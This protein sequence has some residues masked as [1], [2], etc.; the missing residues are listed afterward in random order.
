MNSKPQRGWAVSSDLLDFAIE[1]HGGMIRWRQWNEVAADVSVGGY[2]WQLKS[3]PGVLA[4]TSFTASLQE[5]RADI[6]LVD[7]GKRITFVP[8]NVTILAED[9]HLIEGRH[10]P[11]E[12][13][14]GQALETPWDDVHVGYFD[15]YA[16]WQYLT[17]PFLYSYP[18]FETQEE[19]PWHEDGETWRVL[20]VTFPDFMAAHTRVQRAY[21]GPDGLLRR[22]QYTVDV[23]GGAPGVNYAEKYEQ[24]N[25][26]M[27]PMQRRVYAYDV[28][29]QKIAEPVLVTID[30]R[31][32]RFM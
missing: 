11:R 24:V 23:L 4:R 10:N 30:I 3:R 21:F 1:A 5:Q 26:I 6:L 18:G 31:N 28:S 22:H 16:L 25:G 9:G 13:F 2:L 15:G 19:E 27:V 7:Q 29:G 32:L 14:D 12:S 8:N 17:A 20:R